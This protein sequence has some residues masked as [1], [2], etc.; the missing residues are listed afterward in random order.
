M[1]FYH[2][3]DFWRKLEQTL[4]LLSGIGLTTAGFEKAPYWF[5]IV[6][7]SCG[8]LGKIFFIWMEDK[9]NNGVIDWFEKKV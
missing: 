8:V 2:R 6:L 5:F 4:A 3:T 7:G 9:D 1:K